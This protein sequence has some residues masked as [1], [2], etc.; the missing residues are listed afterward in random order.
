MKVREI[1]LGGRFKHFSKEW[2]NL[3]SDQ[4]V[5]ECVAVCKIDFTSR[6]CQ[7]SLTSVLKCFNGSIDIKSAHHH[8]SRDPFFTQ[9]L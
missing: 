3:T 2:Q 7:A 8:F 4:F 1:N 5:L 6:P 9:L